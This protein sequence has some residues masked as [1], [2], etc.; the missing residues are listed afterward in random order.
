MTDKDAL[1]LLNM[2]TTAAQ[3]AK[4]QNKYEY[5]LEMSESEL[6]ELIKKAFPHL[7][8]NI[9]VKDMVKNI[10]KNEI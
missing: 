1:E 10:L 5:K 3:I 2:Y 6:I 8:N 4:S 7:K 9:Q